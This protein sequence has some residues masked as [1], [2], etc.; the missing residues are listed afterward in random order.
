FVFPGACELSTPMGIAQARAYVVYANSF[1]K[2]AKTFTK[3]LVIAEGFDPSEV[4]FGAIGWRTYK[5]GESYTPEGKSVYPQLA[6]MPNLINQL[7]AQGYDLILVDFKTSSDYIERNGAALANILQWVKYKTYGDAPITLLG[8]SMGGLVSQTA[9]NI[10]EKSSCPVCVGTFVSFDSPYHGAHVPMGLQE[11]ARFFYET[12]YQARIQYQYKLNVPATRQMLYAHTN[13]PTDRIN[14]VNYYASLN[15]KI[16]TYSLCLTSSA[17]SGITNVLANGAQLIQ[18]QV[19]LKSSLD[20]LFH[21]KVYNEKGSNTV[22]FDAYVPT[23]PN[24]PVTSEKVGKVSYYS[25]PNLGQVPGSLSNY[26]ED[27]RVAIAEANNNNKYSWFIGVDGPRNPSGAYHTF[28]PLVSAIDYI[29]TDPSQYSAQLNWQRP[30]EYTHFD[31]V[32]FA[33]QNEAHVLISNQQINALITHLTQTF[34]NETYAGYLP[35][36]GN[37]NFNISSAVFNRLGNY[38]IGN[39]STLSVNDY[40]LSNYGNG[41]NDH[42][43]LYDQVYARTSSCGTT[44]TCDAD[45]SF[46]IGGVDPNGNVHRALVEFRKGSSLILLPNSILRIRDESKLIFQKGATLVVHPGA[47]ILLEGENAVLE[48]EGV[49]QLEDHAVFSIGNGAAVEHGYVSLKKTS[50]PHDYFR[51]QGPNCRIDLSGSFANP[52]RI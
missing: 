26:I 23:N 31:Y 1:N 51:P 41:A 18:Y 19:Y 48:I 35:F 12:M 16:A 17:Q 27:M 8:A 22:V 52:K 32:H 24:R 5:T 42:L 25:G 2:N 13:G 9:M 43:P 7:L 46:V 33:G 11:A 36:G 34:S 38:H 14:W 30:N 49:V 15:K 50:G 45:G 6:N 37:A 39:N 47:Q 44:I 3:P 10:L 20:P 4:D 28:V 29:S 40:S 21:I